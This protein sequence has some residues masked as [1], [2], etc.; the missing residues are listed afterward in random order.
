[1]D[2]TRITFLLPLRYQ[3]VPF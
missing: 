1:M 3:K 2:L